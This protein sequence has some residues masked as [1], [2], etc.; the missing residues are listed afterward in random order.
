[1]CTIR[2]AR[3]WHERNVNCGKGARAVGADLLAV[4][5]DH[6]P[7]SDCQRLFGSGDTNNTDTEKQK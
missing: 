1:M 3:R 7:L 4:A 6:W 2:R 5:V